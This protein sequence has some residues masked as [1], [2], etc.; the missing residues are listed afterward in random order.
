MKI[1]AKSVAQFFLARSSIHENKTKLFIIASKMETKAP[2]VFSRLPISKTEALFN[3]ITKN[4]INEVNLL[5][6]QIHQLEIIRFQYLIQK[7]S[8]FFYLQL[9]STQ[10]IS[11]YYKYYWPTN[12]S[13]NFLYSSK[14][15]KYLMHWWIWFG[16]KEEDFT[17]L[18]SQKKK[19]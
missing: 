12:L 14:I 2:K 16:N 5:C 15:H 4:E 13:T 11:S 1:N 7:S 9:M 6:K 19:N 10:T 17:T 8:S 3:A 18:I